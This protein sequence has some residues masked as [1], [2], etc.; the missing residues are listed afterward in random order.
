MSDI[1]DFEKA[2]A[3]LRSGKDLVGSEGVF[4]IKVPYGYV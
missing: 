2:I 3:G 1:F 4:R